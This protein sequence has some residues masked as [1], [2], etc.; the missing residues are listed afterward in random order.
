MIFLVPES[1]KS[2]K[3]CNTVTA[4]HERTT[5]SQTARA[6]DDLGSTVPVVR[7]I[8]RESMYEPVQNAIP[9]FV[10][11]AAR[12]LIGLKNMSVQSVPLKI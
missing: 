7:A 3:K 4:N 2:T 9:I 6:A 8:M 10:N 12:A 1:A 5:T 11:G